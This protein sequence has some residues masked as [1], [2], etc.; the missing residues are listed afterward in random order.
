VEVEV[1]V[2]AGAEAVKEGDGAEGGIGGSGRGDL[3]KRS[4]DDAKE[5]GEDA[6]DEN[7]SVSH[8]LDVTR[9]FWLMLLARDD[10][11]FGYPEVH[12]GFVPAM[13]LAILRR[14]VEGCSRTPGW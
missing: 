1:G 9:S 10:A 12:L 6:P 7:G 11:R 13:V 2:E 3:P 8:L 5:D 4:A 14:K